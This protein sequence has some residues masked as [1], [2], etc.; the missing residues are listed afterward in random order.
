MCSPVRPSLWPSTDILQNKLLEGFLFVL[1]TR[2]VTLRVPS[3]G[4]APSRSQGLAA[5]AASARPARL[6][7]GRGDLNPVV[8]RHPAATR[9]YDTRGFRNSRHPAAVR[10]HRDHPDEGQQ[11]LQATAA[12]QRRLK[13]ERSRGSAQP[14]PTSSPAQLRSPNTCSHTSTKLSTS[15]PSAKYRCDQHGKLAE[16]LRQKI[17]ERAPHRF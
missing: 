1:S 3:A 2:T 12:Q 15:C 11:P 7:A 4:Q 16:N 6:A 5:P 14:N 8:R 10:A 13:P 9:R 17:P